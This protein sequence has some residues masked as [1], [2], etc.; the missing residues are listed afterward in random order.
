[1]RVYEMQNMCLGFAIVS[2]S[3]TLEQESK[4]FKQI[5]KNFIQ[6]ADRENFYTKSYDFLEVYKQQL[7]EGT[8]SKRTK[9]ILITI[10]LIY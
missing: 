1:M 6:C 9:Q 10:F 4:I 7:K 5:G 8:M 2:L 3:I